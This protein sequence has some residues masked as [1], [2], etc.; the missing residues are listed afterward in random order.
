VIVKGTRARPDIERQPENVSRDFIARNR[1][2][3]N[4]LLKSRVAAA[5]EADLAFIAPREA[6]LPINSLVRN[7][8][9]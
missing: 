3:L 2:R 8:I 7:N 1:R 5:R 6:Q 4:E 9:V